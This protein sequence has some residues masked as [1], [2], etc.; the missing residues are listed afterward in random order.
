MA[1]RRKHAKA[2]VMLP[3][4]RPRLE[5]AKKGKGSYKRQ[6]DANKARS[7]NDWSGPSAFWGLC[8]RSVRT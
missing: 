3:L 2:L 4:Y 1:K 5:A 7:Q 8:F 6:A